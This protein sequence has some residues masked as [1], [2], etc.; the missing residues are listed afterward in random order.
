MKYNE[1][2]TAKREIKSIS[3]INVDKINVNIPKYI[4]ETHNK[5][6]YNEYKKLYHPNYK[7]KS[8]KKNSINSN[9]SISKAY[10]SI[11]NKSPKAKNK[12]HVDSLV[13]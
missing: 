3:T 8:Q 6:T 4:E 1:V 10:I 13:K 9:S 2:Q 12:N 5:M 7:K 11:P